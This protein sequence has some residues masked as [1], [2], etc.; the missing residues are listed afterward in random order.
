MQLLKTYDEAFKVL[1]ESDQELI[2]NNKLSKSQI[3]I[4][5]RCLAIYT[6]KL[7]DPLVPD[8]EVVEELSKCFD[9]SP[10]TIYN[11][12]RAVEILICAVKKANKEYIRFIITENQKFAI[13]KEKELIEA[14]KESTK[15]LSYA[16]Y[17]LVK[18]H[19]LDEVDPELPE[20]DQIQP[21]PIEIS[22]KVTVMDIT[23]TI[24]NEEVELL[25]RKYLPGHNI[26]IKDAEIIG[27][28]REA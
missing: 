20:F 27:S 23:D 7:A 1:F 24:S 3:E 10:R 11:D 18:A 15:D 8:K 9:V 25:K 13:K 26:E 21:Q 2:D 17:I 28:D 12:I 5:R 16:S 22:D 14:G 4:K 19:N 6:R